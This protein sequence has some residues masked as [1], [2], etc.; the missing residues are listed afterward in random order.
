MSDCY[1]SRLKKA[2][3][4]ALDWPDDLVSNTE[5]P[6]TRAEVNLAQGRQRRLI[7]E[8]G[9]VSR[10]T[11]A[12][13]LCVAGGAAAFDSMPAGPAF[14]ADTVRHGIQLGGLGALRT[15]LP[16]VAKNYNIAYDVK[17]F[18]DSTSVLLALEQ[19]ELDVGNSTIQHLIRAI[20]EGIE[21]AWVCGWGGGY[22][23]LVARKGLDVRPASDESLK[24]LIFSRKAAGNLLSIA[25][26][27][28]S[29]NHEKTAV[30]IKSLGL[31]PDKDVRFANVPY[32]N[33]PR[34][35]EAGEV[36]MAVAI[37]IFAAISITNGNAFLFKHLFGGA[38]GKQ[39]IGFIVAR[40]FVREKSD[41]VQRI[42]SSHVE[43]M[44]LFI[45]NPDKQI[46][47]EKKYSRLPDAVVA[48]QERDFL[49]YN[50]RTDVNAIKLMARELVDLG[51]VK[52][53]V[54]SKVDAYVDHSF[55]GK[56]TGLSP[57]ELSKW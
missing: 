28:G 10:R 23:A 14:A 52:E 9:L 48:M 29:I 8:M 17:D 50:Y 37:P 32:A 43:A 19:G 11:F 26:P 21:V 49:K 51:W 4:L 53:D 30:Y 55:L 15:T 31:D 27:S 41:L 1:E 2:M 42:V 5:Q 35:L 6:K 54:S 38:F 18:R 24:A 20:S 16:E 47:Y 33:H 46:E 39:E 22:N 56:A 36:D 34:A 25:A 40:K 45:D 57:A 13:G 3:A 7:M 44:K 12:L